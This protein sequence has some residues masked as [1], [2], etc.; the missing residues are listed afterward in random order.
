MLQEFDQNVS[1]VADVCV[2]V[3]YLDIAYVAMAMLQVY[4][5]NISLF[6]TYVAIV[7]SKCCKK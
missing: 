7:S 1:S 2:Q 3:L 5:T 6:Q 4:V